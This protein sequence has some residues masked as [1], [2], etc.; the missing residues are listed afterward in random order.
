M[1]ADPP[2]GPFRVVLWGAG[3]THTLALARARR[4]PIPG[5]DLTLVNDFPTTS[6]SGLLTGVLAGDESEAAM[7]VDLP[8]LCRSAGTRLVVA[9]GV[10]LDLG[11]R[12]LLLGRVGPV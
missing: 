9:R 11:A 7:T 4:A 10:G 3:H 5:A 12:R 2:A 8:R 6:Y 1:A